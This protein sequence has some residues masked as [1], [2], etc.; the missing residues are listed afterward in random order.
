MIMSLW[1]ELDSD[2]IRGEHETRMII[3]LQCVTS[4][5][6][7]HC[8]CCSPLHEITPDPPPETR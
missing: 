4:M 2:G 5:N 6:N 3:L 1:E 7:Y 8:D